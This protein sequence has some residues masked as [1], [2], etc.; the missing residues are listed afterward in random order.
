MTPDNLKKAIEALD[1]LKIALDKMRDAKPSNPDDFQNTD[2]KIPRYDVSVRELERV[3][4]YF[5][6]Y[7]YRLAGYRDTP[8][9]K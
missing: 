4:Q 6:S 1:S 8:E 5:K 3:Y 7:V 2:D 9:G